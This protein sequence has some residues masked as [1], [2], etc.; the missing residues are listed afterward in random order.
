MPRTWAAY[1]RAAE[2]GIDLVARLAAMRPFAADRHMSV[3]ECAWE[4]LRAPI[5][6]ELDRALALLSDWVVD[7]DARVRRCAVEATRPRGV[8]TFHLERL[9]ADPSPG[10]VLLEP[11]RADASDY[12]RRS[13][14]NW[15]ND[16]SKTRPEW[17]LAVAERWLR[18]SPGGETQWIV[19]HALRTLTKAGATRARPGSAASRDRPRTG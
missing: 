14:A 1:A 12:V 8:W 13:V 4:A 10:L 3:R 15:L 18:K 16:A 11:V 9:K 7:P 19:R 5:A 2:P 6:A 17:V